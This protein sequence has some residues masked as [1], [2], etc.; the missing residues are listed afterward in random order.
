[1]DFRSATKMHSRTTLAP[2]PLGRDIMHV[3]WDHHMWALIP[4]SSLSRQQRVNWASHPH[5]LRN[6]TLLWHRC[7]HLC[8]HKARP[9]LGPL[10]TLPGERGC[11]GILPQCAL[12]GVTH[13]WVAGKFTHPYQSAPISVNAALF[14]LFTSKAKEQL[15]F[16]PAF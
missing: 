6:K 5:M 15:E 9:G 8:T 3:P 13:T 12:D 10:S 4:S 14:S 7:A 16:N 1:M 2:S 11:Q